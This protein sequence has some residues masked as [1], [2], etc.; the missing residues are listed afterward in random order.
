[1]NVEVMRYRNGAIMARD[2]AATGGVPELDY[3]A[4]CRLGRA[5]GHGLRV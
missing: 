3:V 5:V 2:E 4:A 1:M